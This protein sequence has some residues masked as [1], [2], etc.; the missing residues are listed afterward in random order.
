MAT[1]T[2]THQ[3]RETVTWGPWSPAQ[4]LVA[5]LG[6]FLTVLGVVALSRMGIGDWTS[7]QSTIWGFGHTPLMAVI[8]IALGLIIVVDA[9]NPFTA[10][11]TLT[12]FGVLFAIF[13]I[14][15]LIEPA[16]F[17]DWL[18]VNRAMGVLY[19]AVGIGGVVLGALMPV[20]D[21]R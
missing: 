11:G 1:T 15:T 17:H 7:P 16:A 14:I 20:I 3:H 6:G 8:E 19:T 12:G 13:G 2:E 9:V 5:L 18:G 10:R 4:L 21:T